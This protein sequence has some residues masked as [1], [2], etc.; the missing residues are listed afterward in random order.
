LG[1][2]RWAIAPELFQRVQA[3]FDGR[4]KPKYTTMTEWRLEE[5]Q[6]VT[7]VQP[8][9][10]VNS[11]SHLSAKRILELAS[12]AHSL[13]AIQIPAEQGKLLKMLLLNCRVDVARFYH[14]YR[15]P[16]D[17]IFNTVETR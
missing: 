3:V 14:I 15:Q 13:Y 12:K 16:F 10:Q 8:L 5:Q 2:C 1:G 6:L 4:H 7:A 17:L 9:Q 11:A